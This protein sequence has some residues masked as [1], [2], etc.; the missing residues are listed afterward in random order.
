MGGSKMEINDFQ[1][2]IPTPS[3][4][5]R[6]VPLDGAK[7]VC[8]VLQTAGEPNAFR[9]WPTRLGN[10]MAAQFGTEIGALEFVLIEPVTMGSSDRRVT[11]NQLMAAKQMV[12]RDG[13]RFFRFLP[14]F[15]SH[16]PPLVTQ[17]VGEMIG[18]MACPAT[19]A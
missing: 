4:H 7:S 10:A 15:H 17:A 2:S 8:V 9:H 18:G 6:L 16:T 19:T 14:S 11:I 5:I 1:L 3:F 12:A 13:V